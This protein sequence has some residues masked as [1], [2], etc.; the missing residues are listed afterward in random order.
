LDGRFVEYFDTHGG[1][2]VLGYPI[3]DAFVDPESGLL[4]QYTQNARIEYFPDP[5]LGDFV[6]RLN[7]LG[8]TM[9]G[10]QPPLG[11]GQGAFGAQPDCDFFPIS[12]HN[13]CY[14]FRE[15]FEAH[16]GLATFGYPISEFTLESDRIVQYFQGFQLA[17]YPENLPGDQVRVSPLGRAHFEVMGYDKRLLWPN[18]PSETMSYEVVEL[19]AQASVLHPVLGPSGTQNIF[20][21]VRD[22][23][24][25]PVQGAAVTL[26]AHFPGLDRTMLMPQTDERGLSQWALSYEAQTPGTLISL[27]VLVS[28][29]TLMA[30]TRDSFRIWW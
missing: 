21:I 13:V 24:M 29:G 23:N 20:V 28:Q 30:A 10:W 19:Q 14:A 8:E 12:G 4:I 15:Y 27:D 16:G 3:T 7:P 5:Q 26:V 17:F 25:M 22:Q 11:A 2:A 18:P 6:T 9:G 1:L